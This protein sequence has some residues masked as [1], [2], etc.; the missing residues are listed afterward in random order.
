MANGVS[1]EINVNFYWLDLD[2][3]WVFYV[4][5]KG[6]LFSINFDVYSISGMYDIC[7]GVLVGRK[8]GFIVVECMNVLDMEGFVVVIRKG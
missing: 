3:I 1:V 7:Y 6:I 2:W 5:E 4:L 8:G